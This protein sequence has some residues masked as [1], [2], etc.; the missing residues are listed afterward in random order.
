MRLG[1]CEGRWSC[2]GFRS[3]DEIK[4]KEFEVNVVMGGGDG[5]LWWV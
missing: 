2:D 4:F 5:C 3:V 1:P